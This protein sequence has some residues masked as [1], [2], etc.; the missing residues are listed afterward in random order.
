MNGLY[1]SRLRDLNAH[2]FPEIEAVAIEFHAERVMDNKP[3]SYRDEPEIVRMCCR[4]FAHSLVAH[5]MT[6]DHFLARH[7]DP[8]KTDER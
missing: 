5:H 7:P 2:Q 6:L 3:T 4:G 1:D 8:R